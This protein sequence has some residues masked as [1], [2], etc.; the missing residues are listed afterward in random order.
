MVR[1][2]AVLTAFSIVL[3]RPVGAGGEPRPSPQAPGLPA[4]ATIDDLV[5]LEP[6]EL[7]RLYRA[8]PPAA[9]PSGRV[10]GRPVPLSG[11]R[12]AVPVSKAGRLVW[13]GKIFQPERGQAVNRF[14]GLPMI[15]GE[16]SYGHSWL[17]GRPAL[18]LDYERTSTVYGRYRD[19]IREVA[20]G[21]LLG[22]MYERSL[23]QPT[24][25]LIFAL[26]T[27]PQRR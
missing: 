8:A 15:R 24:R 14:F 10:R 25:T 2:A 11:S 21:L 18:I 20:P 13:Q 26:E 1:F 5:R 19:E 17:D 9:M 4:V 3:A 22:L 23:P 7:E 6:A 16:L 12:M 27:G